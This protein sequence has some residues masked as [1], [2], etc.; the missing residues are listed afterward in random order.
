MGE[1]G[2]ESRAQGGGVAAGLGEQKSAL[3][4]GEQGEGEGVG[5]GVGAQLASVAHAGQAGA[6][7]SLPPFEAV[8]EVRSRAR[9]VV[10]ELGRDRPDGAAANAVTLLLQVDEQVTPAIERVEAV[11]LV[12][13]GSLRGEDSV[14][15]VSDHG[16]DQVVLVGEVVI[17]LRRADS[18][19][20]LDVLDAG[21][22]D[23][24][25]EDQFG[26]RLDDAR[27]GEGPFAV[28]FR[29]AGD[30][31]LAAVLDSRMITS[32]PH[33]GV[34]TPKSSGHGLECSLH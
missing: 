7:R 16:P 13:D 27:S 14:G 20:E 21:A 2:V 32:L 12:E 33:F 17:Q 26:G 6:D 11:E 24:V 3:Q 1:D 18:R 34:D 31:L 9:V 8:D 28:N 5:V 15:L 19:A 22:G 30:A 4:R 25:G 23:A 29:V 10:G